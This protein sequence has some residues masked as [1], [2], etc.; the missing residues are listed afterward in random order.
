MCGLFLIMCG[1]Q[2]SL[3]APFLYVPKSLYIAEI[4]FNKLGKPR[5]CIKSRNLSKANRITP[6]TSYVH[7]YIY[8]VM[9]L[10]QFNSSLGVNETQFS[11]SCRKFD[12]R[13]LENVFSKGWHSGRRN[14]QTWCKARNLYMN[15]ILTLIATALQYKKL[16]KSP[17]IK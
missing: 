1:G 10:K 9:V 15:I 5:V 17:L 3:Y 4:Q 16:D 2:G 14:L 7:Y 13:K 11:Y 12:E 6:P 8:D